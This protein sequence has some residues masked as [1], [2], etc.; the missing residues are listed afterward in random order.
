MYK[1]GA[2]LIWLSLFVELL[3]REC[4][5]NGHTAAILA[6]SFF[7]HLIPRLQWYDILLQLGLHLPD[8]LL[9]DSYAKCA[10]L[11][12]EFFYFGAIHLVVECVQ[13]IHVFLQNLRWNLS[14]LHQVVH[15]AGPLLIF[16]LQLPLWAHLCPKLAYFRF[17]LVDYAEQQLLVSG[18]RLQ[19]F[20][21]FLRCR[22]II[23]L[24]HDLVSCLNACC[25]QLMKL[26]FV[27]VDNYF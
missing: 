27:L 26:C 17:V 25:F 9:I 15:F 10:D 1:N 7:D 18:V 5:R 11:P 22:N 14:W 2:D 3:I 12:E 13:L 4:V 20:E 16:F 19:L 24:N 21:K 6:V 8:I 23:I